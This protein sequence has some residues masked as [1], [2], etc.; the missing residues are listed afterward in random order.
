MRLLFLSASG[1]LGGAESCLLDVL[2]SLRAAEPEWPLHLVSGTP[3]PLIARAASLGVAA[4][5]VPFPDALARLGEWAASRGGIG[6]SGGPAR[7]TSLLG[8]IRAYLTDLRTA[9]EASR[10]D[11]VHANGLKMHLL[12]ARA[13]PRSGPAVVWHLHDY[14][15]PRPASACLLRSVR[16]R[17]AQAIA[18]SHSVAEDARAALG[19]GLPI[20]VVLNAVD[21][22]RFAPAGERVDLDALAGLPPAPPDTVRVGLV[23][24]F[25]RWKGHEVFLEAVAQLPAHLP[26]RAY[27]IGGGV[28]QTDGS[29][30]T[31]D[32]LR[33]EA[34]DLG[35]ASRIGFTGFVDRPEAAYRALDV[36][37][38]TSTAPEPFG[39][40]IVE[41]MACGRAVITSGAGGAAEIVT[42]G[43]DAVVHRAG[44]AADLAARIAGL[45]A[46]AS[47]RAA[48]GERARATALR[49]F[50][51]TRLAVD[52]VP[53]YRAAA[54]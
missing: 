32:A 1:Q 18:N 25:A 35:I 54:A 19:D 30:F 40:V 36:A 5:V 21:V 52:L 15:S 38:H 37:V 4:T 47:Q 50:D 43:V 34:A 6:L 39:L 28:Y 24:T 9:I 51:R 12:A 29:Q 26:I 46:S 53:L 22:C 13:V 7:I 8:A 45:A 33:T 17:C 44:D 3:G 31:L 16:S 41:A 14:L 42:P 11:V 23:A 10:P 2:A 20:A 48:L 27:I 49:R